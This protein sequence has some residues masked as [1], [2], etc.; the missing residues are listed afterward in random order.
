MICNPEEGRK[1]KLHHT[2]AGRFQLQLGQKLVQARS[3]R[4]DRAAAE[5]K[6][7]SQSTEKDRPPVWE[8]GKDRQWR[9]SIPPGLMPAQ[10]I[11]HRM[12]NRSV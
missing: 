4:G 11:P 6:E 5:V 2:W 10:A 8:Q 9:S 7:M 12:Q 3:W 1:D